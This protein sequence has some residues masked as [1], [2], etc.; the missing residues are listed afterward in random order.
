MQNQS[1]FRWGKRWRGWQWHRL[2]YIQTICT[3]FQTDNHTNTSSLNFYRQDA[4]P[5]AQPTV[6][7][8]WRQYYRVAYIYFRG[9][10]VALLWTAP[11]LMASQRSSVD[12]LS[13]GTQKGD[14][15]SFAIILHEIFY[16]AG[17]FRC[18]ENDEPIPPKSE[19]NV[20][21]IPILSR[22]QS[23]EMLVWWLWSL[24][25]RFRDQWI[26]LRSFH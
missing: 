24:D 7:K 22:F 21:T 11:E 14:V 1:G 25:S 20:S 16:R 13:T 18:G 12:G 23:I 10:F 19:L 4:P 8:H 9:G 26:D 2:D 17:L 3:S 6:S 15:Y 5:D